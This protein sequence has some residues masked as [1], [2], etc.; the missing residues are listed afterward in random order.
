MFNMLCLRSDRDNSTV[1]TLT[2]SAG[3][4]FVMRLS[5]RSMRMNKSCRD[6]W[7]E[8]SLNV[9][10]WRRRLNRGKMSLKDVDL[11]RE[12]SDDRSDEA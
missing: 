6:V 12:L 8:M 7:R 4:S 1:V 2:A 11:R 9:E 10:T 3:D 5:L